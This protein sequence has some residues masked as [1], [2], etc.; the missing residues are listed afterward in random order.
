MRSVRKVSKTIIP[1]ILSKSPIKI[2]N[3]IEE[4]K[5]QCPDLCDDD[6]KCECGGNTKNK[7][8]WKHQIRWAVADLKYLGKITYSKETK[9]YTIV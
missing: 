2:A 1:E 9:M 4:I 6:I 8:E 7:P 5:K 3:I